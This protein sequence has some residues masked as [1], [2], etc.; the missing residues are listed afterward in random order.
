MDFR[1][2]FNTAAL[3]RFLNGNLDTNILPKQGGLHVGDNTHGFQGGNFSVLDNGNYSR[4]WTSVISNMIADGAHSYDVSHVGGP[5]SGATRVNIRAFIY[6]QNIQTNYA[7][8][9]RETC[10]IFGDS[11]GTPNDFQFDITTTQAFTININNINLTLSWDHVRSG[12]LG[13]ARVYPN[14]T[15]SSSAGA[16]AAGFF[17]VSVVG[18][19]A[20]T[21][22]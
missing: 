14:C 18:D 3:R 12:G 1:N 16:L 8:A 6:L 13:Y 7:F 20:M 5:V 4:R 10:F 17:D 19:G 2:G 22:F 15:G 9:Y 11:A 21:A